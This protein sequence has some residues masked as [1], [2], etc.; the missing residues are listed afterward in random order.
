[1]IV[2][3]VF[4]GVALLWLLTVVPAAVVTCIREQWLYSG[5]GG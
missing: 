3:V 5:Q 2:D 4:Y 1:M